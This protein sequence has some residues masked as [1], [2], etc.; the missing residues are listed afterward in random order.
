MQKLHKSESFATVGMKI[1]RMIYRIPKKLS[2]KNHKIYLQ[3][4]STEKT[5]I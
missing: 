3:Q 4:N 2:Q 1:R 5:Y